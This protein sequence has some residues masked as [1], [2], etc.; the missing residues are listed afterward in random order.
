MGEPLSSFIPDL[1]PPPPGIYEDSNAAFAALQEHARWHGY[2]VATRQSTGHGAKKVVF[3]ACAKGRPSR[4]PRVREQVQRASS[5]SATGCPFMVHIRPGRARERHIHW[6]KVIEPLHNHGPS[7]AQAFAVHRRLTPDQH[8]LVRQLAAQG[9]TAVQIMSHFRDSD[10]RLTTLATPK[11][12]SNAIAKARRDARGGQ[13]PLEPVRTR[14]RPRGSHTRERGERADMTSQQAAVRP[15]PSANGAADTAT[16][17]AAIR[18]AAEEHAILTQDDFL[19]AVAW[20]MAAAVAAVGAAGGDVA[21]MH[22]AAL[23]TARYV[24]TTPSQPPPPAP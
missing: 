13:M 9:M 3:V 4:Q 24:T 23:A 11:D 17:V 16:S 5:S 12:L 18:A 6:T 22:A 20:K 15:G 19:D 2:A 21:A 1:A 7:D 14:G 10:G 8:D